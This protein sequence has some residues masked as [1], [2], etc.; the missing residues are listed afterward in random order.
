M[1]YICVKNPWLTAWWISLLV[2]ISL[3]KN[4]HHHRKFSPPPSCL[5]ARLAVVEFPTG[6]KHPCNDT[7]LAEVCCSSGQNAEY[8]AFADLENNWVTWI[9]SSDLLQNDEED[10]FCSA[11][12]LNREKPY[13][14]PFQDEYIHLGSQSCYLLSL[15]SSLTSVSMA[16]GSSAKVLVCTQ[17]EALDKR[18]WLMRAKMRCKC[19][20]PL[21]SLT[22]H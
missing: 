1:L 21:P 15:I 13:T 14:A 17:S 16:E 20:S 11:S 18:C 7:T 10:P 19:H 2:L 8:A 3:G 12:H 6:K 22:I 4:H 5:L 9:S